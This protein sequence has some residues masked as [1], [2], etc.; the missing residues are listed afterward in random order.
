MNRSTAI[1]PAIGQK[2]DA[3]AGI[4]SSPEAQRV[5]R[6]EGVTKTYPHNVSRMLLRRGLLSWFKRS[7]TDVFYAL[8]NVSFDLNAATSL[9]VVGANG[10]G[11]STL[12]RCA[13]GISAPEEGRI[14]VHGTIAALMELGAGFHPDLTGAE[15]VML[16][17]SLLGLTRKQT[18]AQF[19]RIVEFSGLANFIDEPL[20]TYSSGMV[21]RLAFSV[22]VRVDPDILVIDEVLSVGDIEFQEKCAAEIARLKQSGK[23][24]ICVAHDM[25]LLRKLC[26]L[27]LWLEHGELRM[28]GPSA[29]VLEAYKAA[30]PPASL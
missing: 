8:R 2:P 5:L 13:T 20:R 26:E 17:A 14:E 4:E 23:T 18:N 19:D 3:Q 10:A 16:N 12:L 28:F 25:N 15:N 29:E 7:R 22:A 21:L 24:L 6:F 11:K 27:A 9:A 30:P 1:Q